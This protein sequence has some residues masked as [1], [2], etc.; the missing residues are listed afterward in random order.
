MVEEI[1]ELQGRRCTGRL[2]PAAAVAASPRPGLNSCT[3]GEPIIMEIE[4]RESRTSQRFGA[5]SGDCRG[6]LHAGDPD[7][8][9]REHQ[10]RYDHLDEAQEAGGDQGKSAAALS[11]AGT[12]TQH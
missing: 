5:D 3:T 7:D 10:W 9:R 2:C 8:E 12:G 6:A 4:R 11:A 1:L